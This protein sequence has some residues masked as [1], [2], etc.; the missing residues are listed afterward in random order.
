[1]AVSFGDQWKRA[2]E[3]VSECPALLAILLAVTAS[4]LVW[5]EGAT[6]P[7]APFMSCY[8]GCHGDRSMLISNGLY[9]VVLNNPKNQCISEAVL[10]DGF[11]LPLHPGVSWMGGGVGAEYLVVVPGGVHNRR[12]L[13]SYVI[14]FI[15]W[16]WAA[17][18]D[19]FDL[20]NSLLDPTAIHLHS[21]S[22]CNPK[23]E[24]MLKE[25]WTGVN[26]V[27]V[28]LV[29]LLVQWLH[30]MKW[31]RRRQLPVLTYL[32]LLFATDSRSGRMDMSSLLLWT[33]SIV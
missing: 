19:G 1:M 16:C 8:Y 11:L 7:D 5:R 30:A 29:V 10:C 2:V 21:S 13:L 33:A 28:E 32:G 25:I 4:I 23:R 3:T 9:T 31:Q 26:I 22:G 27:T 12:N 14:F 6:M 15:P 17:L 20:S 18:Q 24:E